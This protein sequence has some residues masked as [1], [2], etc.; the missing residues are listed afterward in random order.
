MQYRRLVGRR[1]G[2][3]RPC[4]RS[5]ARRSCRCRCTGGRALRSSRCRPVLEWVLDL[6]L[7]GVES[8][9]VIGPAGVCL[10]LAPDGG[11][12]CTVAL[13][14][15][16]CGVVAGRRFGWLASPETLVILVRLD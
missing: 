15:V 1:G 9:G 4:P 11:A 16:V 10:L 5:L 7:D 3:V 6:S 8:S 13:C 12:S 2:P 14:F